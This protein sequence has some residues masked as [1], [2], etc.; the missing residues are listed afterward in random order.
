MYIYTARWLRIQL[1]SYTAF[2]RNCPDVQQGMLTQASEAI[3]IAVDTL[4]LLNNPCPGFAVGIRTMVV[5]GAQ[6]KWSYVP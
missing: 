1:L 4:R 3:V 6:S 2:W 5:Q